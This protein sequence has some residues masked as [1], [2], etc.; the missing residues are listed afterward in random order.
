[1]SPLYNACLLAF[2]VFLSTA[3][4]TLYDAK[5]PVKTL[6]SVSFDESLRTNGVTLVEFYSDSYVYVPSVDDVQV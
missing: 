4:C 5:S 6:S 3:F 1:M 2:P